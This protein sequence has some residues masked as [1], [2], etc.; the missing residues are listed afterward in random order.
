MS[1]V[2][3]VGP[4]HLAWAQPPRVVTQERKNNKGHEMISAMIKFLSTHE[5]TSEN[6]QKC[7]GPFERGMAGRL[8]GT[9]G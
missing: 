2:N 3:V 9:V 7:S 6:V 1:A 4:L 8:G 5:M